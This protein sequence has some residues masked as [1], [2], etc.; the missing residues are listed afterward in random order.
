MYRPLLVPLDGGNTAAS[1]LDE[2][3]ALADE[4]KTSLGLLELVNDYPL[5]VE[6]ASAIDFE[7]YRASS[8]PSG[9][10]LLDEAARRVAA[11]GIGAETA[12]GASCAVSVWRKRSSRRRARMDARADHGRSA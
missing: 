12:L 1:G 7:R 11:R 2:T 6:L 3:I 9:R 5:M 10:N 4:L 8:S